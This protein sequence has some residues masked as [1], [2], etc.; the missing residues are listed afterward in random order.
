M[1]V[2]KAHGIHLLRR[3]RE[4]K[5]ESKGSGRIWELVESS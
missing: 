5:A 1:K 2:S 4:M 3:Q